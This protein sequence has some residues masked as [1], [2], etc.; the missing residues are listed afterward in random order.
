LQFGTTEADGGPEKAYLPDWNART[1]PASR[2]T[3]ETTA[4]SVL[5]ILV[6]QSECSP[7]DDPRLS[8]IDALLLFAHLAIIRRRELFGLSRWRVGAVER[9]VVDNSD[10]EGAGGESEARKF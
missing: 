3:G 7:F 5:R 10:I 4:S 8:A 2:S 9:R 1:T 6:N